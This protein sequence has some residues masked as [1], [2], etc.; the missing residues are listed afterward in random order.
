MRPKGGHT[1][2]ALL[3]AL[4][5]AFLVVAMLGLLRVPFAVRFWR[6]M[7]WLLWV[8]FIVVV[9]AAVRLYLTG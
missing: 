2:K 6:R 1:I 9:L 4:F 7:Q 5:V 8:Y 3:S